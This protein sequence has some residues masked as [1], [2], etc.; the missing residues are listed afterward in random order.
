M[1]G[2]GMSE[3]IMKFIMEHKFFFMFILYPSFLFV[4]WSLVGKSYKQIKKN[5]KRRT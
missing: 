3:S 1:E 4:Y 2:E 5:M